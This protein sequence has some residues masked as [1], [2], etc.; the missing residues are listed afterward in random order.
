MFD[1]RIEIHSPGCLPNHQDI[2][3]IKAG[4]SVARN[5]IIFTFATKEIPYR[6][7]GSGIRRAIELYPYIE[8]VNNVDANEFVVIIKYESVL[9]QKKT[10]VNTPLE[11][12][13]TPRNAAN[14][15]RPP[16]YAKPHSPAKGPSVTLN[17]PPWK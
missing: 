3:K 13:N 10:G 15:R 7:I 2:A 11:G 16:R 1:D 4:V 14:I 12:V 9:E 5:P 17:I 6:G 8:F